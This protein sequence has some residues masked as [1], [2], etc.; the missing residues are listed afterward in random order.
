MC[1]YKLINN[2]KE[3]INCKD[4]QNAT[5]KNTINFTEKCNFDYFNSY[6]HFAKNKQEVINIIKVYYSSVYQNTLKNVITQNYPE[7]L[8]IYNAIRLLK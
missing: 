1:V 3:I 4:Y 6:I 2:E 7:Y 8:H 5:I